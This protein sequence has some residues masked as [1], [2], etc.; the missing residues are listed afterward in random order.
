MKNM[1][2][3]KIHIF[4]ALAFFGGKKTLSISFRKEKSHKQQEATDKFLKK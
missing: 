3:Y 1:N 2:V 4:I